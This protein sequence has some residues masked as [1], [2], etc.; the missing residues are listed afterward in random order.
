MNISI[1]GVP[2]VPQAEVERLQG[3][4]EQRCVA[5]AAYAAKHGDCPICDLEQAEAEVERLREALR[6]AVDFMADQGE[7]LDRGGLNGYP[8][9]TKAAELRTTFANRLNAREES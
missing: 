1:D 7:R 2:Y 8:L 5:H 4:V 9:T 6:E 3:L